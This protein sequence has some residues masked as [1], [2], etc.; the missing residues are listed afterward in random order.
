MNNS[1]VDDLV[2][3]AVV[4]AKMAIADTER[5]LHHGNIIECARYWKEQTAK[6]FKKEDLALEDRALWIAVEQLETFE[7]NLKIEIDRLVE[8]IPPAKKPES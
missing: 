3:Q 6:D 5:H 8:T 1:E 2:T 7:A 4:G